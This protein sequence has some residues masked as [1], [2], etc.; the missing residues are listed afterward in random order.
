MVEVD[1]SWFT[2][3]SPLKDD[4]GKYCTEYAIKTSFDIFETASLPMATSAQQAELHSLALVCTLA[5][6]KNVNIYIDSRYAFG[7]AHDFGML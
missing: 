3:D 1:F 6:G 7:I 4:S 2:D 5:K